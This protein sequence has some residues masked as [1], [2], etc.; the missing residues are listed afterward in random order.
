MRSD[1][2]WS[3]ELTAHRASQLF[4][5]SLVEPELL[6]AC[7]TSAMKLARNSFLANREPKPNSGLADT[8]AEMPASWDPRALAI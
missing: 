1:L 4:R 2:A 3:P 7:L 6:A 8:V 5:A